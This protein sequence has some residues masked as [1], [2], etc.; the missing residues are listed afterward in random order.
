MKMVSLTTVRF[1]ENANFDLRRI[2]TNIFF[3]G[4]AMTNRNVLLAI[5]IALSVL[6]AGTFIMKGHTSTATGPSATTNWPWE[7]SW[8]NK[9]VTQVPQEP[10]IPVKPETKPEAPTKPQEDKPLVAATYA[11]AIELAKKHD[12]QVLVLFSAE[13]CGWCTKMKDEVLTKPEIKEEI[14]N[15]IF[16]VVDCDKDKAAARKF[17]VGVIPANLVTDAKELKVKFKAG[18]MSSDDYL[19]WLNSKD[20][21]ARPRLRRL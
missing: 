21:N 16:V 4:L 10:T 13:W 15:Y 17:G 19:K 2:N 1:L 14:K 11:E 12:K 9:P 6:M 3:G 5:V 20:V 7:N 8:N 18:Y